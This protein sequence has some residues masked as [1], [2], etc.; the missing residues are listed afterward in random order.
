[1]DGIQN[2]KQ[3]V[4]LFIKIGIA[5]QAQVFLVSLIKATKLHC[6]SCVLMT[7]EHNWLLWQYKYV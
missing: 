4:F 6:S 2:K 1:M 7:H 3:C 5:E